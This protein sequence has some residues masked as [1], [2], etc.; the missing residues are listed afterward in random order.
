MAASRRPDRLL[1]NLI[2][3]GKAVPMIVVMPNG[4]PEERSGG[5]FRVGPGICR[6]R[7]GLAGRM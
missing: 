2:K 6:F 3:D 5:N 1:D 7:A 4:R